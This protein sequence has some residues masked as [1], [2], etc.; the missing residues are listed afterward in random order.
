MS[1][2]IEHAVE[3]PID[4]DTLECP[5]DSEAIRLAPRSPD[6]A[7]DLTLGEGLAP[8]TAPQHPPGP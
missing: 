2:L 3:R 5:V 4:P 6:G 7:S 1:R 8:V